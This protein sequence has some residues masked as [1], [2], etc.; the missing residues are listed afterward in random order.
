M[1]IFDR[2]LTQPIFNLLALI[3]NFVADFGIAI[4]ILTILVQLLLWPLMKKQLRQTKLMRAIQP[5]L[6]KIKKKAGDNKMLQQQLMMELYREKGIKPMGQLLVMAIQ[7]PILLAIFRVV[8][9]FSET[10]QKLHH[11]SPGQFLYP[12][13]DHFGRVS[14]LIADKTT[15]LFGVIDL[16]RTAGGYWPALIL[17]LLAAG[18]QFWQ[19][20]QIMPQPTE[21]KKLREIFRDAGN[22][23]KVDQADMMAVTTGKMIYFF[24][25][26]T[27]MFAIAMPGA[28]VLYWVVKSGVAIIQQTILLR[29]DD[30]DLEKIA[31]ENRN[32]PRKKS[33]SERMMEKA[34]TTQESNSTANRSPFREGIERAEAK[35]AQKSAKNRAKN[36]KEAEVI[37]TRSVKSVRKS[38]AGSS[39]GQTIVRRIKAK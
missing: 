6:K 16:T 32:R 8:Q 3:Y 21:N 30:I 29:R 18:L 7:L 28:V 34:Q 23:E 1:N 31:E 36:A 25:V 33:F 2:L 17:A 26:M 19:S 15:H 35:A 22:G 9:I 24:P 37:E 27:F 4:I 39:G 12:F 38:S 13:L 11:V 14:E 5:E 20:K 10:Y